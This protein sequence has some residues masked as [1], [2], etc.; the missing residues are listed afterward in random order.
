MIPISASKLC[1]RD[2]GAQR[3]GYF[4]TLTQKFQ[5][6]GH[7]A[8]VWPSASAQVQTAVSE[9]AIRRS[10]EVVSYSS[11]AT[12]NGRPESKVWDSEHPIRTTQQSGNSQAGDVDA[13]YRGLQDA[14]AT[15]F[16]D[17]EKQLRSQEQE[18]TDLRFSLNDA[19]VAADALDADKRQLKQKNEELERKLKQS[20][21][22]A[23]ELREAI[24]KGQEDLK[25]AVEEQSK[26]KEDIAKAHHSAAQD[27]EKL[28]DAE[29]TIKETRAQLQVSQQELQD[30]IAS[31]TKKS[32]HNSEICMLS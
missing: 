22:K 28:L 5:H 11:L 13:G 8:Q 14:I 7:D 31:V 30:S 10:G 18:I 17:L 12:G 25:K 1:Q 2:D 3:T 27:R 19:S 24:R 32:E 29:Q 16:Q 15:K 26:L 21:D 23:N 20:D 6:H 4:S 9:N